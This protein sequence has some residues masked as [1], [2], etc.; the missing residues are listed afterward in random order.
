MCLN[1]M[2][3]ICKDLTESLTPKYFNCFFS[4]I[5]LIL[6][7]LFTPAVC[8]IIYIKTTCDISYTT[9]KTQTDGGRVCI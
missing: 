2:T 8:K 5:I 1:S 6:T 9:L 7:L 4:N 3:G